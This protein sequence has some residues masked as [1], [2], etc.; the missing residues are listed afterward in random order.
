MLFHVF[1]MTFTP[2]T[3]GHILANRPFAELKLLYEVDLWP[4]LDEEG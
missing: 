1:C 3:G 2:E 4:D